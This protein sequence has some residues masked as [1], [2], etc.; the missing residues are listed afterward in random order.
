MSHLDGVDI[1]SYA[2]IYIRIHDYMA[3]LA[4][5]IYIYSGAGSAAD[6]LLILLYF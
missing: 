3:S 1:Y 6:Y 4:R 2:H 5:G